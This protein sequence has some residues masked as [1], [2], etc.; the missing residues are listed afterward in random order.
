MHKIA[1]F[2]I[3]MAYFCIINLY[4]LIYKNSV[5]IL[6]YNVYIIYMLSISRK[7]IKN[8][9]IIKCSI[10]IIRAVAERILK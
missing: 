3:E 1:C 6:M 2:Y 9:Y 7:T 10:T 4:L 8:D 5:I